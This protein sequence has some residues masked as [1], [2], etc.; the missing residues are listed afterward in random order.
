[1][2]KVIFECTVKLEVVTTNVN[3]SL[4]YFQD[5]SVGTLIDSDGDIK[6]T[7]VRLD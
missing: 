1:M 2:K 4:D 5:M 3:A 7:E 6:I